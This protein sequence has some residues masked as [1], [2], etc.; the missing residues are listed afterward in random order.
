MFER[1][2][3]IVNTDNNNLSESNKE[4]IRPHLAKY[5]LEGFKWRKFG[6][7]KA[8]DKAKLAEIS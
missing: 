5:E 2:Q 8:E 4:F 3:E 1:A 7:L 6:T